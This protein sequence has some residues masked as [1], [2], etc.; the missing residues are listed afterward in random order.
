M[1]GFS[2]NQVSTDVN[3]L[4]RGGSDVYQEDGSILGRRCSSKRK[5]KR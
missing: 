2:L 3:I 1:G 5:S 4:G